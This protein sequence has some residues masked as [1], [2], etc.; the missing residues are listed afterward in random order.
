LQRVLAGAVLVAAG[1]LAVAATSAVA[2]V[3]AASWVE[4]PVLPLP[5]GST[6]VAFGLH[7]LSE[8]HILLA[9]LSADQLPHL[10]SIMV[11]IA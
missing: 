5:L 4:S 1:I 3:S 2:A 6:A 10:A 8:V 9:E 7:Q 11:V